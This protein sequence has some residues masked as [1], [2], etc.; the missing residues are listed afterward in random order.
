M[1]YSRFLNPNAVAIKPSGIRKYFD[2]LSDLPDALSLGVGEPDFDTPWNA[3]AA[4]VRSIR[5]GRT[6][7]T[8]NAGMPALREAI[9][10]FVSLRYGVDYTADEVLV[11]VGASE[12]IDLTL[13][14]VLS[15]GDEV[16]IPEPC[17]VSY[18]PCVSLAYGVPVAV[19]CYAKDDFKLTL[20][21]LEA[22]ITT[23]T[24][25]LVLPYPNNP[26]GAIMTREDLEPIARFAIQH[27]LLVLSDEIYAELTYQGKHCSIASLPDMRARTVL[28]NGFSKA[29][30]MTG[31][32]LGYLCAPAPLRKVILKIHQFSLMCAP[33]A[34]QYA[35]LEVLQAGFDDDFASVESMRKEYDMRRRFLVSSLNQM[36]LTCFMP[37]G[38]FYAFPCVRSLGMDGT[39]FT[40]ALL[41]AERLCVVPGEAF[42]AG[43][44]DYVRISYAYSMEQ[45][46]QAL[47]RMRRF[48]QSLRQ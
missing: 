1:D 6:Q 15:A 4:A 3:S 21:A 18:S 14:A 7:Y 9:A 35:G 38:A 32:R 29:F 13:R 5:E 41:A 31:W 42:G 26:T 23:K 43:G 2:V 27:D 45:I 25:V 16:L 24:K 30:A 39:Q 11:T 28:I 19:P 48:V 36:G 12:G 20:A 17:F 37:Q 8:S 34:S 40:E 22:A 46:A 47:E 44:K 10:R 33:T